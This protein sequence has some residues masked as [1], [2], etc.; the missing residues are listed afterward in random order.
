MRLLVF[1]LFLIVVVTGCTNKAANID[2]P[3]SNNSNLYP[4][5]GQAPELTNEVWI[6]STIPLRLADLSGKVVLLDMWT[7]G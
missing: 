4:D 3:S 7:F 1:I 5:L 2:T 6:N